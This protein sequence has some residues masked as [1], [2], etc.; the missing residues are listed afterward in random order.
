MGFGAQSHYEVPGN[1]Q[2]G[3]VEYVPL[4]ISYHLY[5]L[6]ISKVLSSY[7]TGQ[8]G[9]SSQKRMLLYIFT[10]TFLTFFVVFHQNDC[11]FIIFLSFF[12]FSFSLMKYLISPK[13]Y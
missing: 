1:L 2:V 13:E 11:V 9:T 12:F 10:Y 5:F 3:H 6:R 4:A 7:I 8:W